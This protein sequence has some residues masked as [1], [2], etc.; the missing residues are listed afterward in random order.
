MLI[1]NY[2]PIKLIT[3]LKWTLDF[4]LLRLKPGPLLDVFTLPVHVIFDKSPSLHEYVTRLGQHNPMILV[5]SE[6]GLILF[7]F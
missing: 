1:F 3:R 6:F 5:N 4:G 7:V 2:A